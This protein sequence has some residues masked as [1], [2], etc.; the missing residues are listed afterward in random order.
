MCPCSC[1]KHRNQSGINQGNSHTH[2]YP[3]IIIEHKSQDALQTCRRQPH[4]AATWKKIAG[5]LLQGKTSQTSTDQRS[6]SKNKIKGIFHGL[7]VEDNTTSFHYTLIHHTFLPK[8]TT[9]A[10]DQLEVGTVRK[11]MYNYIHST[12]KFS[13]KYWINIIFLFTF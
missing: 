1:Y 8:S 3:D 5:V 6:R 2:T 13:S 11:A 9:T 12:C 10:L 7:L 4:K